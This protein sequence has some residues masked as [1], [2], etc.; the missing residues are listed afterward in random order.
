MKRALKTVKV[1]KVPRKRE[2]AVSVM[3]QVVAEVKALLGKVQK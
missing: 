2:V 1:A 3:A